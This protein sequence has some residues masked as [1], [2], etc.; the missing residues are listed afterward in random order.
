MHEWFDSPDLNS[1]MDE[2]SIGFINGQYDIEDS[3]AYIE[4]LEALGLN[5]VLAVRQAQYDRC[6]NP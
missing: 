5:E 2:L 3:D 6:L 1:Y 4:E